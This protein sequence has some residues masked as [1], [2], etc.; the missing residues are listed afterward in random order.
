MSNSYAPAFTVVAVSVL[1]G[2]GVALLLDRKFFGRGAVRTMM[3]APFLIVPIAA[4]VF[5]GNG[6]LQT[7]FGLVRAQLPLAVKP[8]PL[9]ASA[10]VRDECRRHDEF[11]D[12]GLREARLDEHGIN[13]CKR[14]RRKGDPSDL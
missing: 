14:G 7:G 9:G 4:A 12:R 1:I 2:L 10:E 3:I 11:S 6:M 5:W 8:V 13:N